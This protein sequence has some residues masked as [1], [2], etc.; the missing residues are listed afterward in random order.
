MP[1]NCSSHWH[2]VALDEV[3]HLMISGPE[4]LAKI[5][6]ERVG[7]CTPVELGHPQRCGAVISIL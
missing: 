2:A 1:E 7:G 4:Q 6:V 5:L 3:D